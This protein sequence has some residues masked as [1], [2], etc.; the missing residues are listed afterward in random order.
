[1]FGGAGPA[2]PVR[3]DAAMSARGENGRPSFIPTPVFIADLPGYV[4]RA[5]TRGTGYYPQYDPAVE[6]HK[7]KV[8]FLGPVVFL[9]R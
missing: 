3:C 9:S 2:R 6:K 5:D 7:K 1:M 8:R 4:F